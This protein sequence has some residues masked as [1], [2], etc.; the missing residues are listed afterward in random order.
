MRAPGTPRSAGAAVSVNP[1]SAFR[2]RSEGGTPAAPVR[3]D[4][5]MASPR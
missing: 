5:V 1:P 3:A 2:R 4:V